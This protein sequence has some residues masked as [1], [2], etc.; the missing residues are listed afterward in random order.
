VSVV[1]ETRDVDAIESPLPSNDVAI[2]PGSI[3][4]HVV[5]SR[6]TVKQALGEAVKE[7]KAAMPALVDAI[8]E[9]NGD[10]EVHPSTAWNV[11]SFMLAGRA[12]HST[13]TGNRAEAKRL[14][15]MADYAY[16][17]AVRQLPTAPADR[18]RRSRLRRTVRRVRS[19]SGSRGDPPDDPDKPDD[20]DSPG[21][22][23]GLSWFPEASS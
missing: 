12:H 7:G 14:A 16:R 6:T 20:L 2:P 3:V 22:A 15:R 1:D 11:A 23:R 18:P 17:I 10:P 5:E 13:A 8:I 21:R 9:A 4:L 19:R